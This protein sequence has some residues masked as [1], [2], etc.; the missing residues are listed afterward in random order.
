MRWA[1]WALPALLDQC[2]SPL[3]RCPAMA[4][5]LVDGAHALGMLGLDLAALGADYVVMN[6]HKW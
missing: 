5:V 2:T 4:Q 1:C 6:C 3:H